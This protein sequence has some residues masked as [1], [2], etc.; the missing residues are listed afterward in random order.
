MYVEQLYTKCLSEAAYYIE[1][2]KEA[3]VIDPLRETEPYIELAKKRGA[4]IKYVLETH[5]HADFVSG[6]IDLAKKTDALIVFGPS[7]KP[8]FKAHE[9]QDGEILKLGDVE[10]KVLH[11]PGHTPESTT[12]LLKDENGK[13]YAIFTGDTLF[14][15][16]VGRP[17]LAIKGD[18]TQ[19]DLAAMLYDSLHNKIMPLADDVL[20]YPA[21]GAGSSCG[22][23]LSD[24][25]FATLGD[26]KQNNYA[27]RAE[28]KEQ[29]IKEVT[30]GILPPPQYFP[31]NALMNKS[32]YGSVD[33]VI[34]NGTVPLDL[35]S[36]KAYMNNS[37]V[38]DTRHQDEFREFHVFGSVSIPLQG[39]FATWLGTVLHDI[40]AQYILITEE[41]KEAETVLRMA[42]VGYDNI[43]G[44]LKGGIETWK[45]STEEVSHV[46]TINA[47]DLK[48][49]LSQGKGTVLDV[50]KFSEFGNGHVAGANNAPLDYLNDYY[51]KI[52]KNKTQFVH[53]KS[54]YRSMIACSLLLKNG[55]TKVVDVHG[56]FDAISQTKIS[57]ENKLQ[58]A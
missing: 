43:K 56:G 40:K 10:I 5:Y 57:K 51:D 38:L 49:A 9:A 6:H 22:K 7:A 12:Y 27:L 3:V 4:K 53:C 1:S 36:F 29:F 39:S 55:F 37:I 14:I 50:R 30:D 33:E 34:E 2:N 11:T 45:N 23:N 44:F 8:G 41:G 42:R 54:G 13:D 28:S 52:D 20:V 35:N 15:G 48:E 26:Q 17:D 18:L 47:I 19:K 31:K 25:T 24:D 21:H 46:Q 32:G 16:D 58:T